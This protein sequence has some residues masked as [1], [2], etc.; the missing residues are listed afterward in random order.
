MNYFLT[1]SQ[2]RPIVDSYVS[3]SVNHGFDVLRKILSKY[4]VT[5][6]RD[7][8]RY[9]FALCLKCRHGRRMPWKDAES[10]VN[11]LLQNKILYNTYNNFEELYGE[12]Y[13]LLGVIHFVRGRLTLYDTA[14]NIGQL[15][16][17][18]VEPKDYVYLAAGARE[19]AGYVIGK[20]NLDWR[21][22]IDILGNL[23]SELSSIDI[24]NVLCIYKNQLKKLANGGTLTIAEIDGVFTPCCFY[25]ISKDIYIGRLNNSILF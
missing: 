19:G 20:K 15:L 6:E 9:L 14:L 12:V 21:V 16:N 5:K 10:A 3:K 22:K 8:L 13:R 11:I 24:E 1:Q 23:F 25:P 4:Q 17:P 7:D 18:V 2:L